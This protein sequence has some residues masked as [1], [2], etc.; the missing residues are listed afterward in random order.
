MRHTMVNIMKSVLHM[1]G[2]VNTFN[3]Q[4]RPFGMGLVGF[5]GGAWASWLVLSF[6]DRAVSVR[7]L[8]GDIV[9]YS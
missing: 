8:T 9:L 1:C 2:I 3:L 5:Y 4:E 7:A 6:L